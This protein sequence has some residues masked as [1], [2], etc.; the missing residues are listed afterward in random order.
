MKI[1]KY[2][3]SDREA[4]HKMLCLSMEYHISIQDPVRFNSYSEE[5][6][7][8]YMN[9]WIPKIESGDGILLVAEEND[10]IGFVYGEITKYSYEVKKHAKKECVLTEIYVMEVQRKKGVATKL[11][12]EMEAISK[13][14]G[15]ELIRLKDVHLKN[16][17]AIQLY[18]KLGYKVRV[19]EF[20]KLLS[21]T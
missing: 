1:R 10:I 12:I 4:V 2:K 17:S 7:E 6:I 18:R 13:Q 15:C 14:M 16:E 9:A 11:I 3:T 20:A 19:M 5:V 8:E 21:N